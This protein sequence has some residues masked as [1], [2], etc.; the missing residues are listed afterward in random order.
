MET[1]K[2]HVVKYPNRDNLVMRYR[3]PLTGKQITKSS[4][5][6]SRRKAE[7]EA[8]KWEADLQSGRYSRDAR[9]SWEEFCL[10]W[11][12]SRLPTIKPTTAVNYAATMAAF[13]SLC[14][15]QRVGDLTTS[16]ITAFASE[17]RRDRQ[18]KRKGETETYTLTEASVARH[19]RCIK[20]IA[21]WAHRQGL[22]AKV[23][24]VDMPKRG[25]AAKMKGR[26]ITGEEFDRMIEAVEKVTGPKAAES[27]KALLRG[28]WWSGLR[29]GE[30]LALRWDQ[31]PGAVWVVMDGR[32]S[33]LA[34]DAGSQKSGKVE[35]VPLAPE[36]VEFLEPTRRV[37]G[38]VFSPHRTDAIGGPMARS[39]HKASKIIARIGKAA[40]VVV[41]R[42]KGKTASAHDLRR[43]FGY[44]WSK[45]VMPADL[46]SLM[47]HASIDTTMTYYVGQNATATAEGL[48][49]ALG[50]NLGSMKANRATGATT[51][52]ARTPAN[53][54]V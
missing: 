16:R 46:R 26:P 29:L 53:Q 1:I 42:E 47:R 44:R 31:Q 33:V 23:P 3:C 21:R 9:M 7:S 49:M 19:L 41:D 39:T 50:S 14:R 48:W 11:E 12:E 37:R 10:F 25:V 24:A 54:G 6:T 2:V 40:G 22:I 51:E 43:S 36:A 27:W 34:F 18:R 52:G 4:G 17:L 35:L 38:F 15:P 30:A 45:L 32:R 28:L 13:G 5:E 20:S 8:A